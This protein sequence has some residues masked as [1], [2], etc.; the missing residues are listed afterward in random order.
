MLPP[1]AARKAASADIHLTPNGRFLYGSE[2]VTN[3]LGR[4]G[5]M[6][7]WEI[8]ADRFGCERTLAAWFRD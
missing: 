7:R 6:S 4:S 2:R 5:S 8:I 1:G 3:T